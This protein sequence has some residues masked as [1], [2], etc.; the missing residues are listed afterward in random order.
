MRARAVPAFRR[1]RVPLFNGFVVSSVTAVLPKIP[2]KMGPQQRSHHTSL[3]Y[4]KPIAILS[5]L[6]LAGCAAPEVQ[7][8]EISTP[9]PLVFDNQWD[10]FYKRLSTEEPR[11]V[12][13][14]WREL[15]DVPPP[16]DDAFTRVEVEQIIALKSLRDVYQDDIS[17]Q[18]RDVAHPFA[19]H[20]QLNTRQRDALNVFW[21]KVIADITRVHMHYKAKYNRARPRQYS[22]EIEQ[23]IAPP[24]HPAYPSGHSTDAHTLALILADIRPEKKT[25]LLS[26]ARQIAFNREIG[27]VH[28]RSD[29]EAGY[30]LAQQL[31][32]LLKQDATGG[33]LIND[34]RAA[35]AE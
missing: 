21:A 5:T 14:G 34:L 30:L 16:P 23:S 19:I 8:N 17:A 7:R 2:T 15:I 10:D 27:G 3:F 6:I 11:L 25:Q 31:V 29:T 32:P 9:E 1:F 22:S 26:I 28:Y 24:G 13:E 35:L 18:L 33:A 4:M 20:L 12:P